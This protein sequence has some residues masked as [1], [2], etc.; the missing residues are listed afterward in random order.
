MAGCENDFLLITKCKGYI[1]NKDTLLAS[2]KDRRYFLID[3]KSV[4]KHV[5][6][7]RLLNSKEI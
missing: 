2:A 1:F 6:L 3:D 7:F 4:L 5:N